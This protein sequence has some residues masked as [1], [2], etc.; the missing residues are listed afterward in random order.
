M[1]HMPAKEAQVHTT[2]H[3]PRRPRCPVR[4]P[5]SPRTD[6]PRSTDDHCA[7]GSLGAALRQGGRGMGAARARVRASDNRASAKCR[8]MAISGE[9]CCLE[10]GGVE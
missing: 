6:P 7:A 1:G 4:S 3:A 2:Q 9:G 8:K 10:G 5:R